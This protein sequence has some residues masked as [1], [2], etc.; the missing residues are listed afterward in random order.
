M[1]IKS[2]DTVTLKI[3]FGDLYE[4][5]RAKRRGWTEF[6]MLLL[7]VETDNGIVGWGEP[8]AYNCASAVRA[9]VTDM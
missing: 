1:R 5:P 4:G 3:P 9:A 2:I 8:V 6:D 7:R